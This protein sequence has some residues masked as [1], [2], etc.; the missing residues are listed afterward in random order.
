METSEIET[1]EAEASRSL[2]VVFSYHHKNT[3]KI[4][5]AIAG[6]L[7]APV[8]T[9]Q[10][11]TP[12]EIAEYDLVGFGSGIYQRDIPSLPPRSCR[13]ASAGRWQKSLP[14]LDLRGPCRRCGRGFCQEQPRADPG[15][16]AGEGV[17]GHRRVRVRGVEHEQFSEVYRGAE[18]GPAQCRGPRACRRVCPEPEGESPL[19]SWRCGRDR[20][21]DHGHG[22]ATG[23][24]AS[25]RRGARPLPDGTATIRSVAATHSQ[26]EFCRYRQS[27]VCRCPS[28]R[29]ARVS[30]CTSSAGQVRRSFSVPGRARPHR[31]RP[32]RSLCLRHRLRAGLHRP[33]R[34][35]LVARLAEPDPRPR[36]R[37]PFQPADVAPADRRRD[38]LAGPRVDRVRQRRPGPLLPPHG[39]AVAAPAEPAGV[40]FRHFSR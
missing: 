26:R 9:P 20:R 13:Q 3:E 33:S 8:T 39:R 23:R 7:G 27:P 36:P 32:H 24:A 11:A 30:G 25:R 38:P 35:P 34:L 10:Q 21:D 5:H 31:P 14:L 15:E 29:T 12:E 37:G 6:V 1:G 22:P 16:T 17:R 28:S 40:P 4:A 18:Q 19:K 2:V